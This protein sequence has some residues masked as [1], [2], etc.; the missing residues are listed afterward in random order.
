MQSVQKNWQVY[1]HSPTIGGLFCLRIVFESNSN[2]NFNIVMHYYIYIINRAKAI[3]ISSVCFFFAQDLFSHV[4]TLNF[5]QSLQVL[6]ANIIKLIFLCV[7][8]Q[9]KWQY[10]FYAYSIDAKNR[11]KMAVYKLSRGKTKSP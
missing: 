8:I 6:Q 9:R 2:I 5:D 10:A 4:A 7:S 11:S 1:V 3:V